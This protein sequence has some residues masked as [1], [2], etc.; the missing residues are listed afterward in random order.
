M[1]TV[2]VLF[3][4]K[5]GVNREEYE[6]WARSSDL[7]V[8]NALPSVDAFEVLKAQGLLIGDGPSPYEYLEIIRVPDMAAFGQDLGGAAPQAGAAQFQKYADNPLF[9]LTSAL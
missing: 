6:A 8:V 3:N 4:L 1:Q 9:I 5:P 2:I 7:P